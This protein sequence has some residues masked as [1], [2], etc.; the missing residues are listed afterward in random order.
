MNKFLA[1]YSSFIGVIG[2]STA[3]NGFGISFSV[4][5]GFMLLFASTHTVL[6][7]ILRTITSN[8]K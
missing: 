6:I 1:E 3:L 2:L 7:E 5:I 4:S 8:Q